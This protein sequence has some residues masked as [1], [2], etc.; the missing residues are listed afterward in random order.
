M[1]TLSPAGWMA[2]T[3][4]SQGPRLPVP[5]VSS[6]SAKTTVKEVMFTPTWMRVSVPAVTGTDVA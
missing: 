6:A 4:W 2:A 5:V 1:K 3:S